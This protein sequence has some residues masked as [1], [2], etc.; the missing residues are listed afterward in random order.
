MKC[1]AGEPSILEDP[2][3]DH[4]VSAIL[5]LDTQ[6]YTRAKSEESRAQPELVGLSAW[7]VAMF[8]TALYFY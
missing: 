2:S 8:V 5:R 7:L 6:D 1:N 4:L 3:R